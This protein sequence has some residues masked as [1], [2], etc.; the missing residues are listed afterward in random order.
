VT[1]P[2]RLASYNWIEAKTPTI[3]V[4]GL[5]PLW[6]TANAPRQVKQDSGL[7]YTAQNAARHPKS[8][9]EPL[10]RALYIENP[11]FGI[12]SVDIISDRS[13]IYKLLSFV[14][15]RWAARGVLKDFSM[16]M[17]FVGGTAIL[18]REDTET[19]EL[20]GPD[21]FRG[22]GH[23]FKRA[24]TRNEIPLSTGHQGVVSYSLGSLRLVIRHET[25]G[26]LGTETPIRAS[27]QE[28]AGGDIDSLSESIPIS[29]PSV[30]GDTT[31]FPST[32]SKLTV[33]RGGRSIPLKPTLDIKTRAH[34]KPLGLVDVAPQLWLSQTPNLVRGYH[35]RRVFKKLMLQDVSATVKWW[36]RKNQ[37]KLGRLL[38]LLISL[39]AEGKPHGH[40]SIRYS[41]S[42][43]R[44][45]VYRCA[46]VKSFPDDLY[47]KWKKD[48]EFWKS[49]QA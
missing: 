3:V 34:H 40:V 17:E 14:N 42:K 11:S 41:A 49:D 39:I 25:N 15:P 20:I 5:P 32:S 33:C 35:D 24:H 1:E 46:G 9:L 4:P 29:Q 38:A 10:F 22:Y 44:L 26:Y 8:P 21:D 28:S 7:V 18:H 27:K 31:T 12:S 47:Q 36:E 43:D 19:Q 37:D 6:R 2:R 30:V 16:R 13:N 48:G 23:E 45:S